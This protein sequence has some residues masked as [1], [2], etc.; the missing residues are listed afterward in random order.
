[1]LHDFVFYVQLH[2]VNSYSL[3]EVSG[4]CKLFELFDFV[5]VI[6]FSCSWLLQ[7]FVI[8]LH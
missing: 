6:V 4:F 8:M 3:G 5:Y 1:M 7:I 2:H